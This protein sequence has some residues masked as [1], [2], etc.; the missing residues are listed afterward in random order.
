MSIVCIKIGENESSNYSKFNRLSKHL[1]IIEVLPRKRDKSGKLLNRTMGLKAD[2]NYLGLN[3]N[4]S[5]LTDEEFNRV[6]AMLREEWQEDTGKKDD[7]GQPIFDR[8]EKRLRHIDLS[9]LKRVEIGLSQTTVDNITAKA[10]LKR[11]KQPINMMEINR[12]DIV[13]PFSNFAKVV[14]NKKTGQTLEEELDLTHKTIKQV[15]QEWL[16]QP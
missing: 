5:D 8:V 9:P 2:K 13:I 4:M 6:R 10:N 14:V 16:S 1:D 3:V 12:F 11:T 15:A 7:E